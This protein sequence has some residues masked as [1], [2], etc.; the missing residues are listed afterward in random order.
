MK[1]NSKAPATQCLWRYLENS[2]GMAKCRLCL[3]TVNPL[4]FPQTDPHPWVW[5]VYYWVV[6]VPLNNVVERNKKIQF[7]LEHSVM[8]NSLPWTMENVAC[9]SH[10]EMYSVQVSVLMVP[11]T[12]FVVGG[13]AVDGDCSCWK[14]Q[15]HRNLPTCV[16][17]DKP[18]LQPLFCKEPRL[19]STRS[20][21][22]WLE[23]LFRDF[24]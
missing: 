8:F 19:T 1:T 23:I 5:G 6:C 24:L 21:A 7:P 12:F 20:L 22:V 11:S 14:C 18:K 17:K 2:R 9:Y 3:V 15:F 16:H 10:R 13:W 4:T